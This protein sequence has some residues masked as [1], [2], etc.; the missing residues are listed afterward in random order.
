MGRVFIM[1]RMCRFLAVFWLL[2]MI[3]LGVVGAFVLPSS[4]SSSHHLP[5]AIYKK[6]NVMI[7]T[8]RT[9]VVERG[10]GVGH[11]ARRNFLDSMKT[12]YQQRVAADPNFATKSL[13][14]VLTAAGT[15]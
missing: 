8:V 14:E 6:R 11:N 13:V 3:C 5:V 12:Q 1:R 2:D 7:K 9:M 10:G 15:Q 4:S